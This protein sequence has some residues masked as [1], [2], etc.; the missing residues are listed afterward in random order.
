MSIDLGSR[1]NNNFYRDMFEKIVFISPT[2]INDKTLHHLAEDEDI[3]KITDDLEDLDT[4][5]KTIVEQKLEDE[6]IYVLSKYTHSNYVDG[7]K[8]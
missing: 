5:L 1:Y 7:R 3:L 2:S 6:E 8:V 4:I